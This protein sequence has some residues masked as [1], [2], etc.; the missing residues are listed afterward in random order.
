MTEK[1]V[2]KRLAHIEDDLIDAIADLQE[3]EWRT[4]EVGNLKIE[5]KEQLNFRIAMLQMEE[6]TI[7]RRLQP[8]YDEINDIIEKMGKGSDRNER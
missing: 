1:E 8:L 3:L 4:G 6:R 7:E 5:E 2:K